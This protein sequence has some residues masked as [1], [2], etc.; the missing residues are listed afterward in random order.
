MAAITKRGTRWRVQVRKRGSRLSA[1][2][3]TKAQAT[4]WAIKTE[5]DLQQGVKTIVDKTLSDLL[6]R[7]ARDVSTTK[8]G[9]KWENDRINLFLRDP[10]SQVRLPELSA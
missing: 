6:E 9:H 7:Y 10:V 5:G 3:R 2:F 8:R 4:A 1:T